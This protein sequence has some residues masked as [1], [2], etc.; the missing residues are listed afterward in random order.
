MS[1]MPKNEGKAC[2]GAPVE[3]VFDLAGT[4]YALEHTMIEAFDRQICTSVGFGELIAPIEA[5][6]DHPMPSPGMYW[7]A[8]PIDPCIGL[9]PHH[10]P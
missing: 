6:L 7:L 4:T 9:K 8:F 1:A 5:A 10:I 3:Y 2:S